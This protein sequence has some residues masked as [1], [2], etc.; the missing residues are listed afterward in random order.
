MIIMYSYKLYLLIKPMSKAKLR[1]F[2]LMLRLLPRLFH[3]LF[4][5]ICMQALLGLAYATVLYCVIEAIVFLGK[6]RMVKLV[7]VN[8]VLFLQRILWAKMMKNLLW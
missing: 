2:H 7:A 3:I 6:V 5:Q 8:K 4:I 1:T